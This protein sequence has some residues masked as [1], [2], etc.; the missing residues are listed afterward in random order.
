MASDAERLAEF[1]YGQR[2]EFVPET[3]ELTRYSSL[4]RETLAQPCFQESVRMALEKR[5]EPEKN[6]R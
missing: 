4:P 2:F 3:E 6:K 1:L 5:W